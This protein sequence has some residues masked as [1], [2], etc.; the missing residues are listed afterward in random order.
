MVQSPGNS[1]SLYYYYVGHAA[2]GEQLYFQKIRRSIGRLRAVFVARD[3]PGSTTGF[4]VH[5][6][7]AIRSRGGV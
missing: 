2:F 3:P 4:G 1:A 5:G 6:R 7:A